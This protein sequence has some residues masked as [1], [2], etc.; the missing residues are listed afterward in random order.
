MFHGP[1][2]APNLNNYLNSLNKKLTELIKKSNAVDFIRHQKIL[3]EILNLNDQHKIVNHYLNK[4]THY[5][6]LEE[7]FDAQE[8]EKLLVLVEEL[9]HLVIAK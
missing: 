8:T 1:N 9:N 5:E 7:E 4:G 3:E 2:L 6:E